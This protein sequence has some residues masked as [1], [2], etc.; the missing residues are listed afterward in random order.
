MQPRPYPFLFVVGQF[1]HEIGVTFG[2]VAFGLYGDLFAWCAKGQCGVIGLHGFVEEKFFGVAQDDFREHVAFCKHHLP[3]VGVGF[4][5]LRKNGIAVF[6]I[7]V[8]F[9]HQFF[10]QLFH[11]L[12][13]LFHAYL[14]INVG[15]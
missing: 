15:A 3:D 1:F 10:C 12:V 13:L 4:D 14:I 6:E 9:L 8:A 5:L 2:D 11:L 7:G